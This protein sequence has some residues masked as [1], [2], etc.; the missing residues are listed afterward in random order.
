MARRSN[1]YQLKRNIS[2]RLQLIIEER[3]GSLYAFSQAMAA[4][5]KKALASTL[6]GWLPPQRRWKAKPNGAGVRRID[7]QSVRIPDGSSL[8]EFCQLLSLR[9]DYILLGEGEPSRSQTRVTQ[10]LEQD[11]AAHVAEA[12]RASGLEYWPTSE[13]DGARALS[14]IVG[15][16]KEE[17]TIWSRMAEA[18]PAR[19]AAQSGMLLDEI[20]RIARRLRDTEAART[21]IVVLSQYVAL[22]EAFV[23]SNPPSIRSSKTKYLGVPRFDEDGPP[24]PTERMDARM[25]AA[26][27]RLDTEVASP[28]VVEGL[29]GHASKRSEAKRPS[30]RKKPR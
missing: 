12:L 24:L 26:L 22:F 1:D 27:E 9:S 10:Q 17:A 11:V 25:R 29:A 3:F 8:I 7:W 13:I 30:V 5:G 21:Q 28:T 18:A 16:A 19:L 15:A 20:G 6:R 4:Q 23:E 14:D 2:I